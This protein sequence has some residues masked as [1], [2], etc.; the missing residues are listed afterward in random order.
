MQVF[1]KANEFINIY[2]ED[3]S[4][5]ASSDRCRQLQ[6]QMSFQN[7]SNYV[8]EILSSIKLGNV[9]DQRTCQHFLKIVIFQNLPFK[10]V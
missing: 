1:A 6:G 10:I 5:L 3:L 9:S 8:L 2:G 7:P 4:W